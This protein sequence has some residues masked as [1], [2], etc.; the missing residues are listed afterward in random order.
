MIT[1]LDELTPKSTDNAFINCD[2]MEGMKKIPDKYFDLAIVDP[3][4]GDG[5]V[6]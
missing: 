3:P 5:G 6:I 2:C 4:Y 1:T